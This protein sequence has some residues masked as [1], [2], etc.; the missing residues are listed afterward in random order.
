MAGKIHHYKLPE[1]YRTANVYVH[2]S[3]IDQNPNTLVEAIA[4]GLPSLCTNNGGT[5]EL[6]Q[7]T[8]SGIVS[9]ADKNYDYQLVDYYNP[10]EPNYDLLINDFM[11]IY[12]NYEKFK[13]N[14]NTNPIDIN[15]A[16]VKYLNF[17]KKTLNSML[18]AKKIDR[19]TKDKPEL[20]VLCSYYNNMTTIKNSLESLFK[21]SFK[22]IEIIIYSDGSNDLSDKIVEKIIKKKN[23]VL[24]LKS[25]KNQGLT[26]SLNYMLKFSR[27]RYIARHDA[28]DIS[29]KDRFKHQI[30]FLKKNKNIQVLGTNAIHKSYKK[31][32]IQVPEKNFD[33]KN[34]LSYQNVIIHSS[35]II[36]KDILIKN[37]Y[38]KNFTRCQ[39]YELWL[40][41]KKF[42]NFYNLQKY[43]VI[44]EIRN[45]QFSF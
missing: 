18:V 31:K 16:A 25:N 45:N 28:D 30:N 32:Y 34:K 13:K 26:K 19:R 20:T 37:K 43:L 23:N 1:W 3:W 5:H 6:I 7:K 27:A 29:N 42:T 41:I 2:L 12:N 8:N 21:Q 15:S 44:R 11:K 24:F 4:C 35:I 38:D 10:P 33:I 40:R 17:F 36:L 39:D 22:N 9:N 14:I